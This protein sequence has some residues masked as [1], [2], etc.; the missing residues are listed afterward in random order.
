MIDRKWKQI[1]RWL[2]VNATSIFYVIYYIINMIITIN[3]IY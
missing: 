3:I 1:N 2:D